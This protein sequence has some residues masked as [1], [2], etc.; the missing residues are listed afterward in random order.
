MDRILRECQT[1]GFYG[2][3]ILPVR[4]CLEYNWFSIVTAGID[5]GW[6]SFLETDPIDLPEPSIESE[7]LRVGKLTL[8]VSQ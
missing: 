5:D 2:R 8:S 3:W 7:R 4:M 1:K 6:K